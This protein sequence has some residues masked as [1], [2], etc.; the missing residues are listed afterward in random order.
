[1]N[2]ELFILIIVLVIGYY[3]YSQMN[4]APVPSIGEKLGSG[5]YGVADTVQQEAQK[6]G[7][8][9]KNDVGGA[10]ETWGNNFKGNIVHD[11]YAVDTFFQN[12]VNN[13]FVDTIGGGVQEAAS[14]V[15]SYFEDNA[16]AVADKASQ[17]VNQIKDFFEKTIP[18]WFGF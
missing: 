6:I 16:N 1:M 7:S 12:D 2:D 17:E 4:Q 10:L 9:F 13:F 14:Q 11:A 5:L 15:K 8:F 18:S 3:F